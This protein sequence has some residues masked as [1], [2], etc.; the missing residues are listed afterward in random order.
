MAVFTAIAIGLAA[1]A[2]AGTVYSAQQQKKAA[3]QSRRAQAAEQRRADI[4]AARERRNAIRSSR[5]MRASIEAQAAGTGLIGSSSVAAAAS[6][7]TTRTNENLSFLDQTAQLSQQASVANIAASRY[8]SRAN[9]G[10]AIADAAS[11]GYNWAVGNM[12]PTPQGT[13]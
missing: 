5:V 8:A 10:K 12:A 4:A 13:G 1:V 11:S 3:A 2:V 7:V 6:N 9:T